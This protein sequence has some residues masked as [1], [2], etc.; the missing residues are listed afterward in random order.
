MNRVLMVIDYQKDFVDGALGFAGAEKLEP[1]ILA[2]VEKR[3]AEGAAVVFTLDTHRA[4]YLQ[5]REGR[6]LPVPHCIEGSDGAK[7]YGGLARYMETPDPN[8]FFV[9]KYNF[10]ANDYSFLND[11]HP[12]EFELVGLVSNICVISNAVILQTVFPQAEITVYSDLCAS[13]DPKLHRETM[14]VM[15]GLQMNVK[16]GDPA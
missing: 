9:E 1:G 3:R 8:L 6:H 7:L 16:T 11:R 15:A 4:D 2:L 5:T 12:E 10:G 13:F 14:D